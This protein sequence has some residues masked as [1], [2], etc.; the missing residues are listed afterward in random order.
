MTLF[1]QLITL[2]MVVLGTMATRFVP[3]IIFPPGRP[4][5]KYVSYLGR[6]LPA[7]TLGMLV[8]YSIKDV[9]LVSGNHGIPE[10]ISIGV[11]ALLHIWKR[12]M[13]LSMASGTLVYM[14]LIRVLA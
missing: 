12:N 11:V 5:P 9:S 13:L 8:V 4:T 6:V 7:A 14:L 2:G 1:E 3:F 10:F